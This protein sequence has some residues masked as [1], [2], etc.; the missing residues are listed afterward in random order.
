MFYRPGEEEFEADLDENEVEENQNKPKKDKKEKDNPKK[1][2]I[3]TRKNI[4]NF[5]NQQ[6]KDTILTGAI[7]LGVF[8]MNPWFEIGGI[9]TTAVCA[10]L[11]KKGLNLAGRKIFGKKH[12]IKERISVAKFSDY[13]KMTISSAALLTPVFLVVNIAAMGVAM[14]GAVTLSTKVISLLIKNKKVNE[15]IDKENRLAVREAR[16]KARIEREQKRQAREQNRPTP[17]ND[18]Q[19]VDE[20]ENQNQ[21]GGRTR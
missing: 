5:T 2:K 7:T 12:M 1:H 4:K 9:T 6:I 14:A 15:Q 16:M 13:V 11:A 18:D 20:D 19:D 8:M 17:T 3:I 21:N 10:F